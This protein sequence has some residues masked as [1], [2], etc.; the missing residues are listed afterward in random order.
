VG[1][2]PARRRAPPEDRPAGL[3]DPGGPH[4][5]RTAAPDRPPLRRRRAGPG[6][7]RG[8]TGGGGRRARPGRQGGD[9]RP[10]GLPPPHRGL[11]QRLE[12]PL[13][14]AA[15]TEVAVVARAKINLYL[16]VGQRRDDGYHELSSVM[17]SVDLAD[18]VVVR[19]ASA[20]SNGSP[21]VF[22]RGPGFVGDLPAPPDLVERALEMYAAEVE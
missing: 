10:G 7:R 21:V 9:L 1:P 17:Q 2:I 4:R 3:A 12:G 14:G 5:L 6:T 18:T 15:V 16:A 19:P 22:A 20:A 13:G 11:V 8:G